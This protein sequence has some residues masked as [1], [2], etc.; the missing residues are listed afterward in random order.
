[1]S[2]KIN[3]M[4]ARRRAPLAILFCAVA[5]LPSFAGCT[6]Q[7]EASPRP[8][9]V[10]I[11]VDTLRADRLTPY[12]YDEIDTPAIAALAAQGI[13]FEQAI[14]DTSWTLPSLTSVMTG[15]YPTEH[16]VRTWNH[17][18]EESNRPLAE[19]LRDA[20]YHTAAILGSY[21]VDRYFGL[22][23]GFATYDDKMTRSVVAEDGA[24]AEEPVPT[25]AQVFDDRWQRAAWQI[26]RERGDAYRS[27][28]EVADAAIEWLQANPRTPFFLWVHFFG[29]HERGKRNK[30]VTPSEYRQTQIARYDPY[31]VEM[32][33]QVGRFLDAL[34]SSPTY[35]DTA[36]IFHSD[37]GQSLDEH[38]VFGHGSDLFETTLHVPLIVRL[39]G[40][41]RAG[42]RVPGL[43][44]NLDIFATA[45]DLA[46]V[47]GPS[48]VSR[49]LL[50]PPPAEANHA[51]SETLLTLTKER[52]VEAAGK[53]RVVK[54]VL[55][56]IRTD[57]HKLI[58]IVP[59]P[60]PGDGDAEPLP[61]GY[62]A[63]STRYRLYD[64]RE[65]PDERRPNWAASDPVAESMKAALERYSPL[66]QSDAAAE[67]L[68]EAARERLRNLGYEP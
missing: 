15:T 46:K 33:Q 67:P 9:L 58:A 12:G 53:E 47:D 24:L 44:R 18:L 31:V 45:L 54:N 29:P 1:M 20:G 28:R 57:D 55:R 19:L 37:H 17:R 25:P 21:A 51:Y 26:Q 36:V 8:N 62:V 43:V 35:S 60:A 39:P 34:R 13:V 22:S 61:P 38:G 4:S 42:E 6:R 64:L 30:R 10:L 32:D 48:T 65:D 40:G 41:R 27:D 16:G 2:A 59:S 7:P 52:T 5:A 11:T 49:N 14:A 66:E 23:Q 56:S 50:D 68:D 63:D 3:W